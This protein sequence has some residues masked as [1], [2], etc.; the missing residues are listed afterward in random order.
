[1]ENRKLKILYPSAYKDSLHKIFEDYYPPPANQLLNKRYEYTLFIVVYSLLTLPHTTHQTA[2]KADAANLPNRTSTTCLL[3][4]K[5]IRYLGVV[6]L[7]SA[8]E[9]RSSARHIY[10]NASFRAIEYDYRNL[11]AFEW[12]NLSNEAKMFLGPISNNN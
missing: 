7:D 11:K 1:M 6:A 9:T 2:T 12:F 10:T 3:S 4:T 8:L 5:H